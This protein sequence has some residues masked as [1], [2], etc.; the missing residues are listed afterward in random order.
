[1]PADTGPMREDYPNFRRAQREGGPFRKQAAD[2]AP[3]RRQGPGFAARVVAASVAVA[4]ATWV[5]TPPSPS[6]ARETRKSADDT[7]RSAGERGVY[8]PNCDAARAAGAAPLYRGQPGYR[9]R[10][11]RWVR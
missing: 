4:A 3:P 11:G 1:M 9:D 5:L 6:I 2:P 10:T 7:R 8:Y